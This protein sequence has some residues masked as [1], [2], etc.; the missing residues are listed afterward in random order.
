MPT[1]YNRRGD[2]VLRMPQNRRVIIA[3]TSPPA[4]YEKPN[5]YLP[6]ENYPNSLDGKPIKRCLS[7]RKVMYYDAYC[8]CLGRNFNEEMAKKRKSQRPRR[9]VTGNDSVGIVDSR[10]TRVHDDFFQ[11][12]LLD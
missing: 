3:D 11:L 7:C 6:Y 1:T 9:K 12:G 10:G 5:D 8:P 4:D 2:S